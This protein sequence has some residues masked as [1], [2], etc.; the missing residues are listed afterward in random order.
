MLLNR[1]L[2]DVLKL[3]APL[4]AKTV[5]VGLTKLICE[6]PEM[7]TTYQ[8]VGPFARQLCMTE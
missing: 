6:T 3:P 1:L 8:A 2:G 5:A 7:T 4:E